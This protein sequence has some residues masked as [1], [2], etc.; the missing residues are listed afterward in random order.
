MIQF[1]K[2]NLVLVEEYIIIKNI[3]KRKINIKAK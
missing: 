1:P 3:A 2:K